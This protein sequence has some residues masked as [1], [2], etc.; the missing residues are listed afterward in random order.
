V[1]K[2]GRFKIKI[3]S[4]KTKQMIEHLEKRLKELEETTYE[5]FSEDE[6]ICHGSYE[7]LSCSS[8][9]GICPPS[10]ITQTTAALRGL[11]SCDELLRTCVQDPSRADKKKTLQET[12][13]VIGRIYQGNCLMTHAYV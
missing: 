10:E 4:P 11:S 1:D 9:L 5:P 6:D 3:T 13:I 7:C 8:E 2:H 12:V